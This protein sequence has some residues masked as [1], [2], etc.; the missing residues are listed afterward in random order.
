VDF[1]DSE[2]NVLGTVEVVIGADGYNDAL[3]DKGL[4]LAA[5]AAWVEGVTS[6][7]INSLTVWMSG[8]PA[9]ELRE[10]AHGEGR[11]M[12]IDRLNGVGIVALAK[13]ERGLAQVHRFMSN[14]V[15]LAGAGGQVL[16]PA[17]GWNTHG[18]GLRSIHPTYWNPGYTDDGH[19][20]AYEHRNHIHWNWGK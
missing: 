1:V 2:G 14:L 3:H 17:I 13:T 16:G 8:E 11:A 20:L 19:N 7:H 18:G 9:G 6:F 12:D 4:K 5:T 10:G 15:A